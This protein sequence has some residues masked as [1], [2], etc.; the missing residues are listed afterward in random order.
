MEGTLP[1][2]IQW[3]GGKSNLG[4]GLLTTFHK[5]ERELVHSA[6]FEDSAVLQPYV[7]MTR[8]RHLYQ[9]HFIKGAMNDWNHIRLWN[10]TLLYLWLKRFKNW[11][12]DGVIAL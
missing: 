3:R 1:P 12:I 9:L 7:D 4:P 10:V 2:T 5:H 11:A 6:L 8:L